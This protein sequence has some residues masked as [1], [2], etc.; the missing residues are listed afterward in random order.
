MQPA[1]S[2]MAFR[3]YARTTL[4]SAVAIALYLAALSATAQQAG[5]ETELR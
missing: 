4:I 5:I 1:R 2:D 3:N